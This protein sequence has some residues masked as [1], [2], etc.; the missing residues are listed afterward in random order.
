[1]QCFATRP[2]ERNY[3]ISV[4]LAAAILY[5]T[6]GCSSRLNAVPVSGT[7]CVNGKPVEN[8]AVS[9]SPIPGQA[10]LAPTASGITDANGRFTLSIVGEH[11]ISGAIPGKHR[12][13]LNPRTVGLDRLSHEEGMRRVAKANAAFPASSRDG[14]LTFEVPTTGTT[15]AD[16]TFTSPVGR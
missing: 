5:A 13:T 15:H 4:A 6:A 11:R 16:F 12:V 9:F 8:I 3:R 2:F 7:V 1:M 14:S 10:V